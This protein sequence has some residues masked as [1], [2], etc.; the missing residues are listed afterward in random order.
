MNF[1]EAVEAMKQGKDV[2]TPRF[3]GAR[4]VRCLRLIPATDTNDEFIAWIGHDGK[5]EPMSYSHTNVLAEDWEILP[6]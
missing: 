2:W 6:S 4:S 3:K 5:W 1:G